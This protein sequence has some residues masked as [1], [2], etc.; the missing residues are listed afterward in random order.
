MGRTAGMGLQ[1][2][3]CVCTL[4]SR[5]R[6]SD[7]DTALQ[8]DN[9]GF[10]SSEDCLTLNVVRPSGTKEGDNLPVLFWSEYGVPV[11]CKHLLMR[12]G[13]GSPWGR[14]GEEPWPD[15]LRPDLTL[16]SLGRFSVPAAAQV[17]NPFSGTRDHEANLADHPQADYRY[18]ASGLVAGSVANDA[19]IIFVGINYRLGPFGFTA[20]KPLADEGSLNLGFRD[21]RLALEWV[22]KNI[23]AFGGDPS[24]VTIQ[25]ESVSCPVRNPEHSER[26]TFSR[27]QAGGLSVN[28]HLVAYGGQNNGLFHQ[29]IS[30]SGGYFST[31]IDPYAAA[32]ETILS[33]TLGN[34]SCSASVNAS[35]ADQLACLRS[36]SAEEFRYASKAVGAGFAKDG[37]V[38]STNSIS[39]SYKNGQYTR[40][41][42]IV[43]T[44]QPSS[45]F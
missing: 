14:S 17:H 16:L 23:G 37:T 43:R 18:N 38:F 3:L 44:W 6:I 32:Q 11:E 7:L 19:P 24:K 8:D 26:L 10:T 25:G 1:P 4:A 27:V 40:V 42:L 39:A 41:C 15:S 31:F 30:E 29:A 34:S 28:G 13:F 22:A 35:G 21:Q 36:L 9:S 45:A 5:T 12:C 33:Y 20:N 2:D